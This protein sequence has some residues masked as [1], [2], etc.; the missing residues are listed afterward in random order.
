M[1][2][3]KLKLTVL[4][5]L[6]LVMMPRN[7]GSPDAQARA[8]AF[9]SAS[10][11]ATS[12]NPSYL[13]PLAH[14]P[15]LTSSFGEF[16]T[17]HFHA[18][19]D[20]STSGREGIPVLAVDDGDVVRVRAS[21]IGYGRAVY[22]RLRDGRLAVHA[23][24][25]SIM[26]P[27]AR[28]VEAVQ[29]SL[30]LYRVDLYPEPGRFRVRRGEEI[31]RSGSSGAGGPHFH[32]ELREGDIAINPLSHGLATHDDRPPVLRALVFTPLD[33]RASVNA[34]DRKLRVPL[35]GVGSGELGLSREVQIW[36]RVGLGLDGYDRARDSGDAIGIYRVELL[37]DGESRF[38]ARFDRF[39]YNHNHEV[40]AEFDYEEV[41]VGR[42][43]VRNLFVPGGI[44]GDFHGKLP[45]GAG[46]LDAGD[47]G[48]AHVLRPGIH[49][50]RIFAADAAGNVTAATATVRAA[51]PPVLDRLVLVEETASPPRVE[52]E[53]RGR[54]KKLA[55]LEV[56]RGT[57]A[58]Q[59]FT[60]W[61]VFPAGEGALGFTFGPESLENPHDA[62]RVQVVDEEGQRSNGLIML[63]RGAPA[64]SVP[65]AA[66]RA[67]SPPTVRLVPGS[68]IA[69][70]E[71]EFSSPPVAPP[72]I[73]LPDREEIVLHAL[74]PRRFRARIDARGQNPLG[75][76]GVSADGAVIDARVELPWAAVPRPESGT[77]LALDG[78]VRIDFPVGA[79]F[80]DA[81]VWVAEN[82][83]RA[84]TT[85]GLI[86][87]SPWFRVEP[88]GLPLDRGLWV[89]CRFDST[90][91]SV[92]PPAPAGR[93]GLYRLDD[94]GTLRYE[95]AEIE[96]RG[97]A[98]TS[99]APTIGAQVRH[100]GTF[101]LARDIE[102]PVVRWTSPAGGKGLGSGRPRLRAVVRDHGS[103][104]R[105]DDV[106]FLID[107]RRVPT[108]WDAEA[109][110]MRHRPRV[111]L[112]PG[113]HVFAARATD[114]SGL[115]TRREITV[116]VP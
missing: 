63:A 52:V 11:S 22:L 71:F 87:V 115:T 77:H 9:A 111:A 54:G 67:A 101:V 53:A 106:T 95:G 113:R 68:R 51:G 49:R 28:Y 20:L 55:R 2:V 33:A 65:P 46:I 88:N 80:E 35:I 50:L 21:G 86:P 31:G 19:I 116:T 107:G 72:V 90:E 114:R 5:L 91:G 105:E 44:A 16:R 37:V 61:R 83:S 78:R 3:M 75:V 92:A 94:D 79:F 97:K 104:F 73:T 108:E 42:R 12:S 6:L 13:W 47:E 70:L 34:E 102:P 56:E 100:L 93:V 17:G 57:R 1:R 18:G 26:E 4:G 30:E 103:G 40:E 25:A 23:H 112:A 66:I 7:S 85:P 41:Q 10:L 39:D 27:L 99:G 74:D 98:E 14:P 62:V 96:H 82:P 15:T 110:I 8:I 69:T 89:G 38:T 64:P 76:G 45:A 24:L 29:D 109:R 48:D 60:P 58:G 32:F 43:S 36:G 84:A 59:E 81:Y